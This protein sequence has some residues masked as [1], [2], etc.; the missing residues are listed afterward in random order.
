MQLPDLSARQIVEALVAAL[1]AMGALLFL[2]SP[3]RGQDQVQLP[4]EVSQWFVN[5]DGSCVQC[6][7][8][9]CGVWQNVPQASTLLFD[10]PY[11][12]KVRGGSGPSRVE[13]YADRRGIPCYNVTGSKT[14]EWMQW[15]SKTGRMAAIGCFRA[16]FQTQLY[17]NTADASDAKPYKVRNN[18]HGTTK[19]HYSWTEAEFRKHHLASGQWVVI[20]K[21]PSPPPPPVYAAWWR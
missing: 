1:V 4:G 9:N 14:W 2:T 18:W 17:Q 19:T 16:H 20:L 10:S 15:A 7:I 5:Q 12:P 21:G 6:S 3:A 11:G 8:S 13:A